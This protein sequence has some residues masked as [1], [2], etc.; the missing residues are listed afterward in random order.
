MLDRLKSVGDQ[1]GYDIEYLVETQGG[2]NPSVTLEDF[3]SHLARGDGITLRVHSN[4]EGQ[5]RGALKK[6]GDVR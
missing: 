6:G 2:L 3:V 4:G 1:Q 5:W